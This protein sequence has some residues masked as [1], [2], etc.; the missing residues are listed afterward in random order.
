M[1][2]LR[3]RGVSVVV[4][5]HGSPISAVAADVAT[6]AGMSFWETGAVGQ[7][8]PDSSGGRNFFRLAPLG[9]NLGRATDRIAGSSGI[10]D[11]V[12]AVA[13]ITVILAGGLWFL[14][15][16]KRRRRRHRR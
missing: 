6:Q 2:S 11:Q 3:R 15:A 4:G 8:G 10:G 5:S 12:V 1:E 9:A 13:V 14:P 7:V 16:L